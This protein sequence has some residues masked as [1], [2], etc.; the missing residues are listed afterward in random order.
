MLVFCSL[1]GS[2][3]AFAIPFTLGSAELFL[4]VLVVWGGCVGCIYS[5]SISVIGDKFS[6]HNL[7]SAN[8]A[9]GIFYAIAALLGP[10]LNGAAMQM[11]EPHGLMVSCGLIFAIFLIFVLVFT[12]RGEQENAV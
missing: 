9:F 7:M 4:A 2:I 5:L 6:S 8:A 3:G 1:V 11:W 12:R 10:L